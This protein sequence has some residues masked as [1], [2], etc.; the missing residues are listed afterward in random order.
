MQQKEQKQKD[1]KGKISTTLLLS[2]PYKKKNSFRVGVVALD[3]TIIQRTP[4]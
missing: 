3:K 2:F 4:D 1:Q